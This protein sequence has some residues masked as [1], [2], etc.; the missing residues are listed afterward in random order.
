MTTDLT[1]RTSLKH[2]SLRPA[3]GSCIL[4]SKAELLS[5][6]LAGNIRN[7]LEERGVLVFKQINFTDDEQIAFTKTLGTYTT[8][9]ADGSASKITVN[10][11]LNPDGAEYLKGSLYWHIDGTM[12]EVPILAS[13]LS[14]KKPA[15]KGTGNTGFCNT[16]AAWEALP[17][18]RKAELDGVRAV[19]G[20]WPTVFYY[21]PEPDIAKLKGMMG[22]GENELPLVWKHSSGRKSLVL[23]CTTQR[24]LGK[25]TME[26]ALLIHELRAWATQEQFCYSHEWDEGD[27]VIWDNTGTMH[28]AEWYDP[29]G[30]RMMVRTKLQGEE[31]F[32]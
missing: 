20:V 3:I 1:T 32:A 2:E 24:I 22:V 9:K 19:H 23:G 7:L 12:N 31:P 21:E 29:E 17:E 16:Y 10:A 30:D 4:N 28:R 26:S 8:E 15:P 6:V 25:T 27:L 11:K 5:G 18:A 13:L 14:C